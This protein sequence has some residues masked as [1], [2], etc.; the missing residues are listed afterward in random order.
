MPAKCRENTLLYHPRSFFTTTVSSQEFFMQN[1]RKCAVVSRIGYRQ[2]KPDLWFSRLFLKGMKMSLCNKS[3]AFTPP[4][5][6]SIVGRLAGAY[7]QRLS[8]TRSLSRHLLPALFGIAVATF[9]AS[10]YAATGP[11][12]IDV[13]TLGAANADNSADVATDSQWEYTSPVGISE[14]RLR[15]LTANGNYTLTGTNTDLQVAVWNPAT[16]AN[17]TLNNVTLGSRPT[18][19]RNFAI[20]TGC[21]VTLVGA[22]AIGNNTTD[23]ALGIMNSNAPV[24]INGG[25]TL[26][27]T[28]SGGGRSGLAVESSE[29]RIEGTAAVIANSNNGAG[30]SCASPGGSASISVASGASLNATGSNQGIVGVNCIL[31]SNGTITATGGTGAG[32]HLI[33]GGTMALDGSSTITVIGGAGSAAIQTS[34]PILMGDFVTLTM[35]NNSASAETHPFEVLN[36]AN[37]Y[38]WKL[39]TATTPHLRTDANI[40]VTLAGGATG[41]VQR[42]PRPAQPRSATAVPTTGGGILIALGVLLAGLGAGVLRKKSS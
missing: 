36:A 34:S 24:V 7:L 27:L 6:F 28:S 29:L 9:G 10:A 18:S 16:D 37:T 17:V 3:I 21:T 12:T 2:P 35:I 38:Q 13:S 20:D 11:V 19:G 39:T 8:P 41:T 4:H 23:W 15:L 14:G 32:L 42:E 30:A 33:S 25:G 31:N 40:H 1:I 22:N 5:L 26:T